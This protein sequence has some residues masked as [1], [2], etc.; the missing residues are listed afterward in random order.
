MFPLKSIGHLSLHGTSVL[1]LLMSRRSPWQQDTEM[2]VPSRRR[3][4]AGCRGYGPGALAGHLHTGD[5]ARGLS[6][7]K[8]LGA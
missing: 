1:L 2:G 8:M 5:G 7:V 6:S 3:K 4:D